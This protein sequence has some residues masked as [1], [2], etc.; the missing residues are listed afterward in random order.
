M[1]KRRLWVMLNRPYE[2]AAAFAIGLTCGFVILLWS[3]VVWGQLSVHEDHIDAGF[4]V[5]LLV[6]C[7][8]CCG[9]A[10]ASSFWW[11]SCGIFLSF[12]AYAL[13]LFPAEFLPRGFGHALF[14]SVI[15]LLACTGSYVVR[16]FATSILNAYR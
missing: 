14:F 13:L 1:R 16:Y 11:S 10:F 15:H 12:V 3:P 6:I 2:E 7:G 8:A 4:V 9:V 5:L